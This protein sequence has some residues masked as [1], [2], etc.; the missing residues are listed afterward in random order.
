MTKKSPPNKAL[1][2]VIALVLIAI[3]GFVM[4]QSSGGS[5]TGTNTASNVV[6]RD[7]V[8]YITVEARGGYSPRTT[9]AKGGMPT[10]LIM[11]TDNTYDCSSALIIRAA[12]YRGMLP[13]TGETEIDLGTPK[14]GTKVPGTCG[15]GM[16]S[17]SLSFQ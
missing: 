5:A 16:Y 8:Q 3:I 6:I 10:K 13:Q 14:A 17:F 12:N 11:K 2:I 15:M 1:S 7:G 9:I 4:I